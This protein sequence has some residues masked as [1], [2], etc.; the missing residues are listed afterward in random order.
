MRSD[1]VLSTAP[2]RRGHAGLQDATPRRRVTDARSP[3]APVAP[4]AP[5]PPSRTPAKRT[6][7]PP[8]AFARVERTTVRVAVRTV[9]RTR[10]RATNP[11]P[12]TVTGKG[13]TIASRGRAALAG[14]ARIRHTTAAA[15]RTHGRAMGAIMD[16]LQHVRLQ[17]RRVRPADADRDGTGDGLVAGPAKAPRAAPITAVMRRSRPTR[18]AEA[19]ARVPLPVL[20]AL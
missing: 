14:A 11:V 3:C 7:K 12:R 16:C 2:V 20:V 10:S 9:T 6:V 8:W 17:R 1:G 5:H 18:A 4:T 15:S 13:R 19:R